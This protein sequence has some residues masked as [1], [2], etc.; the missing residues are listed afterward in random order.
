MKRLALVFLIWL[1]PLHAFGQP[2]TL[3]VEQQNYDLT[4]AWEYVVDA[5][6]AQTL[7]EV[8]ARPDWQPIGETPLTFGVVDQASWT[9]IPL[10]NPTSQPITLYLSLRNSRTSYVD[11]IWP[12]IPVS[13]W[14]INNWGRPFLLASA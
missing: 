2:I 10:V 9:R 14:R 5:G 3:S 4:T 6:G 13:R 7:E 1:W 8:A 12:T 11:F